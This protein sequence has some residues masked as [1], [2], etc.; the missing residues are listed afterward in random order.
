MA[1]APAP[2]QPRR[3]GA[4][5]IGI[6]VLGLVLFV[7]IFFLEYTSSTKRGDLLGS[8]VYALPFSCFLP[9]SLLMFVT[10]SLQEHQAHIPWHRQEAILLG[11][12][13]LSLLPLAVILLINSFMNNNLPDVVG[14]PIVVAGVLLELAIVVRLLMI[15]RSKARTQSANRR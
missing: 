13:Y 5:G 4:P 7:L 9:A 14:I 15:R 10:R 2:R 1:N 6:L 3:L 11:L 12:F 8:I